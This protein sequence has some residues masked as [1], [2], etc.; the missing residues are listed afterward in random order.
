MP[1][2]HPLALPDTPAPGPAPLRLEL[3]H[4]GN[5]A[6]VFELPL[7]ALALGAAPGCDVRLPGGDIPPVLCIL[8]PEPAGLRLRTLAPQPG[9]NVNG[10]RTIHALLAP[11]D[12][13]TF[14]SFELRVHFS[15][16]TV[17]APP[18]LDEACQLQKRLLEEGI[19]RLAVSQKQ[20]AD[21]RRDWEQD[22]EKQ[23]EELA[24]KMRQAL[25]RSE[26]LAQERAQLAAERKELDRRV[27]E[28]AAAE[29]APSPH[30]DLRLG[31]LPS[32]SPLQPLRQQLDAYR[33]EL[34][35]RYK[36]RRDHLLALQESVTHAARKVQE[37]KRLAEAEHRRVH[38]IDQGLATRET[39]VAARRQQLD[40]DRAA[41][42]RQHGLVEE[43]Q[44]EVEKEHQARVAELQ[45]EE[46]RQARERQRLDGL[47]SHYQADASRLDRQQIE[48]A[49]REHAC[50]LRARLLE[51]QT[52]RLKDLSAGLQ[53]QARELEA[54][55]ARSRAVADDA[56]RQTEALQQLARNHERKAAE[57]E[58]EQS[59]LAA[60]R[61][62]TERL[63]VELVQ[64][65]Q[66]LTDQRLRQDAEEV[67]LRERARQLQQQ[68]ADICRHREQGL[69]ERQQGEAQ[70]AALQSLTK[71]LEE[72]SQ[73]LSA[74]ETALHA[75]RAALVQALQETGEKERQLQT[76]VAE[77]EKSQVQ[78]ASRCAQL[79]DEEE[80]L[81]KERASLESAREQLR[82]Q[83]TALAE[84]EQHLAS[85]R[86]QVQELAAACQQRQKE[87]EKQAA[88][89]ESHSRERTQ[90][91]DRREAALVERECAL[92]RQLDQLRIDWT[93]LEAERKKL[94]QEYQEAEVRQ[95]QA[96]AECERLD[97]ARQDLE[98]R[99]PEL[100][101]QAQA[102]LERLGKAREQLREHLREVHA[103]TQQCQAEFQT[104]H[105]ELLGQAER[106]S[107]QKH[108]LSRSQH[109]HRHA[110]SSFRQYLS[111]WQGQ[112]AELQRSLQHG[113]LALE[114]RQ[115]QLEEQARQMDET[116]S[117]LTAKAERLEGQERDVLRRREELTRQLS[118]MQQ[119]YR[120]KLR[121]LA[122]RKLLHGQGDLGEALLPSVEV[123]G[124]GFIPPAV[125]SLHAQV[126]PDDRRLADLLTGMALVDQQTLTALLEE[127]RQRGCSL[128]DALLD[129]DYLTPYQ[130]ELIEAGQLEALV[131][132]PLRIVDRLR[133]TPLETVYRVF[134]PR[135]G[136]EA[137]L[138]QLSPVVPDDRKAEFR[139][140]FTR[141][142]AVRHQHLAATLEVLEMEGCPAVQQEWIVG[143]PSGE[144]REHASVPTVWL[145]LLRQAASG[146]VAAHDAGLV[147]GHLHAG[148][149]LL[150]E[151]GELKL[152]GLGEPD[153]LFL[154]PRPAAPLASDAAT[155]LTALGQIAKR[156]LDIGPRSRLQRRD[157]EPL[158]AVLDRLL[159]EDT[160]RRFPTALS[161]LED[162]DRVV[163][164]LGENSV[165]WEKLVRFVRQRLQP[166]EVAEQQQSA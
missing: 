91:L 92:Q 7:Q 141:A 31:D 48:L 64:R 72:R 122:E 133:L 12:Q 132:G 108:D 66:Q 20:L 73:T 105:R 95:R 100:L 118:D 11:G 128:R 124:N 144:W 29:T 26:A 163:A 52:L 13:L 68:E 53:K 97:S 138:R 102:A 23:A 39:E 162:L 81:A 30:S 164:Q 130:V 79:A 123:T 4:D 148:R 69:L 154:D 75:E 103:Y 59:A 57:L 84:Q 161:L 61:G 5:A 58:Q 157:A 156:W 78:F 38:S 10:H 44:R 115:A 8:S 2:F 153:W 63:Q 1:E 82:L 86:Q 107:Q 51:E 110:V 28:L 90:L 70:A 14:G 49:E 142:A 88:A 35:Q 74:Q 127:A 114:R 62:R 45:A 139:S 113:E 117:R 71:Q 34:N 24:A 32:D 165:A 166:G 27:A 98:Q 159:T 94:Q 89:I 146:L 16:A 22:A 67:R 54:V 3:R 87:L 155:D 111:E 120:Q 65:E 17:A 77:F 160:A 76:Q 83:K 101:Q 131:L 18:A 125:L 46:K 129:G 140:R 104:A 116:S 99:L 143:L 56:A 33:E 41:L 136:D 150:T 109:E 147:H 9:I 43:W 126:M 137:L 85:Q 134:D 47:Q 60:L 149:I 135:R 21:D 50:D 96:T 152:C 19:R 42:M 93:R 145:Q 55:E 36:Q 15:P 121:E 158:H 119:W 37:Q 112:F 151:D 106:I 6:T 40:L 80:G 25:E